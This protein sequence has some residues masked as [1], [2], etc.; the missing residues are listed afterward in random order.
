MSARDLSKPFGVVAQ[1]PDG[2]WVWR[3]GGRAR[4]AGF[5]SARC[6]GR[7]ECEA[8]LLGEARN[9]EVAA[10]IASEGEIIRPV[11]ECR[12]PHPADHG[13]A[14]ATV[15]DAGRWTVRKG[16]EVLIAG[17]RRFEALALLREIGGMIEA[18]I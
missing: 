3:P 13:A 15:D 17:A 7:D 16:A 5:E 18:E 11:P 1:R 2:E 12:A 6:L 8:R 14:V 10:R 4:D 9:A